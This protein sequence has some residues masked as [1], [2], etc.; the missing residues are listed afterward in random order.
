M[1]SPDPT[2]VDRFRAL[3]WADTALQDRL[4]VFD[5]PD[6]FAV[7]AI[8]IAA[9]HDIPITARDLD[10]AT[11]TDS[12]G[13]PGPNGAPAT[14]RGIPPRQ[15]LPTSIVPSVG[16][17]AI[18]W[19][20][21]AGAPLAESFFTDSLRRVGAR[22]LNRLLSLCTPLQDLVDSPPLEDA[23]APDGF[24]FHMSRCGS[25]LVSQMLAAIPG[26]IA[27][28]EPPPVDVVV[29]MTGMAP[30]PPEWQVRALQAMVA[31]LGRNRTGNARRY[32]VKTD[33]WHILALP[34]F[35]AAFPTVPWIFLYRD[36]IEVIVSQMRI[37]GMMAVP[38]ELPPEM[39]GIDMPDAI[40]SPDYCSRVMAALCAAA[41]EGFSAGGGML[42]NYSEL[43]D[44]VSGRILGHF[45]I[46][47]C[48]DDLA[49]MAVAARRDA[50]NGLQDFK[51]D[52]E[53]KQREASPAIRE[54][55]AKHLAGVY[56]QLEAR[57]VGA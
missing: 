23:L 57:R 51:G 35:R 55:V 8:E 54:A 52:A 46:E 33:A 41:V 17:P 48:A 39:F 38:S 22:P 28:S 50:K 27:V 20:H 37:S 15:W 13:I 16:G 9:A 4:S 2:A 11:Q 44:A 29:R 5:R 34:L 31:A 10:R 32:F 26:T 14:A 6:Q 3:L 21:F 43:P 56:A 40:P 24:I 7:S 49:A 1:T 47:P 30:Q 12:L 18:R 45:G 42:V 25:T 19:S 36:P 53:T